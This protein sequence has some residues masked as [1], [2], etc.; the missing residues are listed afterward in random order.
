MEIRLENELEWIIVNNEWL[1]YKQTSINYNDKQCK[2]QYVVKP[3]KK[4]MKHLWNQSTLLS[5]PLSTVKI[6]LDFII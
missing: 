6:F 5:K 4:C 2:F 1:F 3:V